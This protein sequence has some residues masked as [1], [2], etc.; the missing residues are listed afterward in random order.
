MKLKSTRNPDEVRSFQEAVFIGLAPDGGL[1][2]PSEKMDIRPILSKMDAGSSFNELATELTAEFLKDEISSSDAAEIVH[3]AFYF[4]PK[5]HQLE[6]KLHVLELFHGGTCA[7]KD[8]GAS[9]LASSMETFL[10]GKKNKAVILT[11]TSGDTG[12]AVARAFHNKDNIDV[13]IL[14]PSG[15]VSPLQEKQLTTLGGNIHALEV[16]GSFDDCQRMVK[17]AFNNAELK[18]K[19]HLTSANSINI[20]RLFPQSF[21]YVWSQIQ[22]RDAGEPTFT[23]PSGN[24]GNLTAGLYAHSWGLP[25]K[26]FV[27]AT[28]RNDVVPQYLL[29]GKYEPRAS[30]HTYSNAMDVGA[31]SN[32]ERMETLYKSDVKSFRGEIEGMV[33]NDEETAEAMASIYKTYGYLACP[34]TAVGIEASLRYAKTHP[35]DT[36]VSLSTAH[37]GKFLEVSEEI[38]G[39]TPDLPEELKRLT[40]R[41][42]KAEAIESDLSDLKS[43]LARHF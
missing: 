35:E 39:V 29:S 19:H 15:R 14:Y 4:E 32:F 5:L 27:A 3:N 13:V 36:I 18:E 12:S 20:G 38:L 37:P 16:N 42:K 1:Y 21:Y 30:V 6:K 40:N 31:P 17:E 28:N 8:F 9:F 22:L 43:F 7:F 41:E 24:F 2:Y 25:V 11:A 33:I 10:K 23:V 34:H 26:H